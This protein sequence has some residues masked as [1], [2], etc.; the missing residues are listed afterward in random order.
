MT[1]DTVEA[2][3]VEHS[4]SD[5][6]FHANLE[7]YAY[8]TPLEYIFERFKICGLEFHV[9]RR[10]YIPD[11]RSAAIVD[12]VVQHLP[13]N[14]MAV[15]VGTGCGWIGIL[16][17]TLREDA[18]VLLTDPEAGA[19]EVAK[20]NSDL[21]GVSVGF[22]KSHILKHVEL[23]RFPNLVIA[24]LSYGK[25]RYLNQVDPEH[26]AKGGSM[27]A[28]VSSTSSLSIYTDLVKN[29][30]E[31]RYTPDF[32]FEIGMVTDAAVQEQLRFPAY[33]TRV[34]RRDGFGFAIL[35]RL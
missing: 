31:L 15:D 13:R 25:R 17:K 26:S 19:L 20:H 30:D 33:K 28:A 34:V 4:H 29:M 16:T 3:I 8:G 21:H 7:M 32:M 10:V 5:A 9:D 14:G 1:D 35:S 24:N 18:T 11:S 6:D 23:P 22:V 12:L 27:P 2:S